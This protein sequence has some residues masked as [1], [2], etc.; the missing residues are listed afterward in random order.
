M[1]NLEE[2]QPMSSKQSES[3]MGISDITNANCTTSLT[4]MTCSS[5]IGGLGSSSSSVTPS[6]VMAH[7]SV[8]EIHKNSPQQVIPKIVGKPTYIAIR[9]VHLLMMENMASVPTTLGGGQHG[10]LALVTNPVRYFG[11]SGGTAFVLPWN[12]RPVPIHPYPFMMAAKT[13][14]LCLQHRA[15]LISFHTYHN[16]NKSLKN[17]LITL[18]ED[19]YIAAIKEEHIGYINRLVGDMLSHLYNT[20]GN[21]SST[22]LR[23]SAEKM[24]TAYDLTVSI[25]QMFKCLDDA[26]DLSRDA[27]DARNPYQE[28]QL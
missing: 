26:Q 25:E 19:T 1:L 21:I 7:P 6:T 15:D 8:E 3:E 18:V 27:R 11:I 4:T 20:Y 12:P 13:E 16:T 23:M 17:Q 24:C 2:L 9:A 14:V 5:P 22:M 10:H 28:A